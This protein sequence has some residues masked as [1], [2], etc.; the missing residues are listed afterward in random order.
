MCIAIVCFPS[1][2]FINF[3]IHRAKLSVAKSFLRPESVS[4]MTEV[5][6]QIL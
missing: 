5:A 3:E 1:C 4:L 2:D 6:L